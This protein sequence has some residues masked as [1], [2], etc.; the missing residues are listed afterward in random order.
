MCVPDTPQKFETNAG[1][2]YSEVVPQ[3][4]KL[5]EIETGDGSKPLRSS[6]FFGETVSPIL[7]G[8]GIRHQMNSSLRQ[9]SDFGYESFKQR[10]IT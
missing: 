2:N 1:P 5:S 10:V 6:T 4:K 3:W 8:I 9:L 7:V